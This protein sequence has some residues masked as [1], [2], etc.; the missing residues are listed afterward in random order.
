M[1]DGLYDNM[2]AFIPNK[3]SQRRM[4]MIASDLWHGPQLKKCRQQ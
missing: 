2:R 4:L 3:K 1:S